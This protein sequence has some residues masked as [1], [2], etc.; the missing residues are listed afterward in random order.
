MKTHPTRDQ[1]TFRKM[2]HL[3][4]IINNNN[5]DKASLNENP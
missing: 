2:T 1:T 3:I 5:K 4:I